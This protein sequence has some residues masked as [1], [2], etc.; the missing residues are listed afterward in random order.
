MAKTSSTPSIYYKNLKKMFDYGY[1]WIGMIPFS[2]VFMAE[3]MFYS[4]QSVYKLYPDGT[5]SEVEEL[6]D[7]SSEFMYGKERPFH[8]IKII[9]KAVIKIRNNEN[10][11]VWKE[12][13]NTVGITDDI[14]ELMVTEGT[15]SEIN[16][17]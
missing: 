8:V 1:T 13:M 9:E 4:N 16:V 17:M 12:V 14:I 5:E 3:D 10:V 11:E 15:L 7:F 2:T 6:D